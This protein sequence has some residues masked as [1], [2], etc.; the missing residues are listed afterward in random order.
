MLKGLCFPS[1]EKNYAKFAQELKQKMSKSM[2]FRDGWSNFIP[3]K[4]YERQKI[5]FGKKVKKLNLRFFI[6]FEKKVFFLF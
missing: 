4:E 3:K 2:E 5:D 6:L 1:N